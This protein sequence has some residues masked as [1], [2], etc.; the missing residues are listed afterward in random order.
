MGAHAYRRRRSHMVRWG[1]RW[2]AWGLIGLALSACGGGSGGGGGAA[3]AQTVPRFA[4]LVNF[5]DDTVSIYTVDAATGQ[6][7]HHGY[8][9]AGRQPRSVAVDPSSEFAYVANQGS[10]DVSAYTISANGALT[11]IDQNGSASGT[12]VPAGTGPHSVVVDPSGKFVYIANIGGTISAYDVTAT[13]ALSK[14]DCGSDATTCSGASPSDFASGGSAQSLTFHPSG[15]FLYVANLGAGVSVFS[16]TVT[17]ALQRITCSGAAGVCTGSDFAAGTD[18]FSVSVDPAGK[19]AY[20]ANFTSGDVSA[21]VID[22]NSGAL[23]KVIPSGAGS[24]SPPA[25]VNPDSVAIDPSGKFVYVANFGGGVTAFRIVADGSGA[26]ER[27]NCGAPEACSGTNFVAGSSPFSARVDPSGKFLYVANNGS[28]DVSVYSIADTGFLT[29]LGAV[30]GRL[31]PAELAMTQGARPVSYL[32]EFAY[33]ANNGSNDVSAFKIEATGALTEIDQNGATPGT[34]VAAG[35]QPVTVA[36]D[37]SGRFAYVANSKSIDVWAYSINGANGA[38][39]KIND[40]GAVAPPSDSVLLGLAMD[41]SAKFAYVLLLSSLFNPIDI[42]EIDSSAGSI[43]FEGEGVDRVL[44][45]FEFATVD[46]SGRFLYLT[47]GGQSVN[48]LGDIWGFT[49]NP[50]TG[51]LTD[52]PGSPLSISTDLNPNLPTADPSGRFMYVPNRG[53]NDVSA[54]KIDAA[55]GALTE[56]DQ[57]GAAPGTTVAAGLG[58]V[59]VAVDPSGRFAYVANLNSNDVSGYTIAPGGGLIPIDAHP[60]TA[61]TQNFPAGTN[62]NSIAVDPSGRFLYVTNGGSENVSAYSIESDGTLTEIPGSPFH[63]G[64]GPVSIATT[65][66]IQ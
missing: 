59:S 42:F 34:T 36:T 3:A 2:L 26:L 1:V 4:Y 41:P 19:F 13:G 57:N 5:N 39:S 58:P 66:I 64:V 9:L 16:V 61:G 46:P 7:R 31:G 18:P 45:N 29:S 50:G 12:T 54:F 51:A 35:T 25:G 63:A 60:N 56:I 65:G 55:T 53:S 30:R 24:S 15:K 14:I 43:T 37:L 33:V 47:S 48:G 6:L 52:V 8:V 28:H 10:N 44:D 40:T 21:F 27:F 38:L 62:P 49:V 23:S 20:V 11:E 22:A 32:R 17:G